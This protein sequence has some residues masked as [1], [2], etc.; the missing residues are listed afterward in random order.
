LQPFAFARRQPARSRTGDV[1]QAQ[2]LA[3]VAIGLA[4]RGEGVGDDQRRRVA[5]AG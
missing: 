2:P 3:L 1:G 4:I 5:L